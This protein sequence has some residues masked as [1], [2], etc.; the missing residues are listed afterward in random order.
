MVE[1]G[2][3]QRSKARRRN[4]IVR[5]ALVLFAERGYDATTIADI[6]DAAE[7]APRTVT[8]YFRT[9]QD[10]AMARF[11]ESAD[12]LTRA[13]RD[14]APGESVT[15]VMGR[16]MLGKDE[17]PDEEAMRELGCRMFDANPELR[18]LRV[19]RMSEAIAEGAKALAE[20]T[21]TTPDALGPRIAVAA[22][23]AIMIEIA[24]NHRDTDHHQAMATALAFLEAGIR[25]L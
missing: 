21:G 14:R 1:Q 9:K 16:W 17:D 5:S 18:A 6:A 15:Q 23:V 11:A 22:A 8:M 19:H 3:R 20:D 24:D 25:T 13:L 12:R 2:L 4:A 10:I 7:V